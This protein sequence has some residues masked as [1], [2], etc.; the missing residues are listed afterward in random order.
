MVSC[1][2]TS[3]R[4]LLAAIGLT[5]FSVLTAGLR[6]AEAVDTSRGE[7][8]YK[9]HCV[10]CHDANVHWRS[11]RLAT[12]WKSLN[13]QVMRWQS[14]IQLNWDDAD[15]A[16]TASYLNSLYYQFPEKQKRLLGLHK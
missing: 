4:L 3:K 13:V 9:T 12:D 11:Q 10:A 8:L 15:I 2:R 6:D 16:S 1:I 5:S 7:L 14:A